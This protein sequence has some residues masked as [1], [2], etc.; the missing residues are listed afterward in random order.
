MLGRS[1]RLGPEQGSH[2]GCVNWGRG[3][4]CACGKKVLLLGLSHLPCALHVPFKGAG[5]RL[6]VGMAASLQARSLPAS[7]GGLPLVQRPL[8]GLSGSRGVSPLGSRH[9]WRIGSKQGGLM[10]NW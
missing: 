2:S 3:R 5:E 10:E 1:L 7:L 8:T 6:S 4:A 9:S